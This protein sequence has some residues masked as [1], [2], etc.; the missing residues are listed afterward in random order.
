MT[1]WDAAIGHDPFCTL[2]C[3]KV[4]FCEYEANSMEMVDMNGS[5]HFNNS[6]YM[7]PD[8]FS[9]TNMDIL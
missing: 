9:K 6:M 3:G 8:I 5:I 1:W 7:D 4:I 2:Q